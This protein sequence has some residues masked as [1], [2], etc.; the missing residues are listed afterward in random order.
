[1][2]NV[3]VW[4]NGRMKVTLFPFLSV[5]LCMMGAMIMLL[6]VVA[7]N[8]QEWT[9]SPTTEAAVTQT[10]TADDA[11][12]L[13]KEIESK[14]EEADWYAENF[15]TIGQ[16]AEAEL[17]DLQAKLAFAERE[18]QKIED[19]LARLEQLTKQL[20]AESSATPEEVEHLKRLL[21]QQQR[22]K[23]EAELELA[24]L[25]KEASQKEKSYAIIPY[26]GDSGTYRRPIYIECS[27]N[28]II[29]QPEGI[30]LVPSD[31]QA[32]D[33][34]GN[35]FDTVLRV[36]RQYY[37]ETGQIVR[38]TEP[39]P[40]MIIRPSGVEMYEN[41]LSATHEN[42]KMATGNWLK[43][44]GYE[45]VNEDW[46]ILYPQADAELRHRILQQL[47]IAR[48]RLSGYLLATRMAGQGGGYGGGGQQYRV[49]HLGNVIPI[50]SPAR[51]TDGRQQTADGSRGGTENLRSTEERAGGVKPPGES[52]PNTSETDGLTSAALAPPKFSSGAPSPQGDVG[53]AQMQQMQQMQ[54]SPQR[55]PN[56]GLKGATQYSS[57]ISRTVR[58]RCEANRF[59]LS[60]QAGLAAERSI[61]IGDSVQAAADQL[62]RAVWD[63]Q[64]SWGVAGENRHWRPRLQVQVVSGGEQRLREL[65]AL[66]R[67]SGMVFE[68]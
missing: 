38:G 12:Q 43:D 52:Q 1:M 30:E 64:E 28:K 55:P 48:N 11:E 42:S 54:N 25:Q 68:E 61:P 40:L 21:A 14:A 59:V 47:E 7:R 35:P 34:P 41:A 60:A 65:K 66:L 36:I 22:R 24:E 4:L 20:N 51:R 27:N 37:V 2:Q 26:R 62:V 63:F 39:Y 57:G 15:V 13:R 32:P 49:D 9:G 16:R 29:I 33:Q 44:F 3:S 17:A 10:M 45:I 56:W 67:N 50:G 5:L 31:F 8:V 6:V 23:A 46:N 58:I 53:T 18:T 19:E